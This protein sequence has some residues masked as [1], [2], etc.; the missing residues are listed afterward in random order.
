MSWDNVWLVASGGVVDKYHKGEMT[1]EEAR[2]KLQEL[3]APESIMARL[4]IE[5]TKEIEE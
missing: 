5:Q 3:G 4:G 1:L 2:A